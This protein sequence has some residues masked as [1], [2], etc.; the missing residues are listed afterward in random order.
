MAAIDADAAEATE[1]SEGGED[2]EMEERVAG[3]DGG[4][5]GGSRVVGGTIEEEETAE[6]REG[7]SEQRYEMTGALQSETGEES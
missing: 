6:N 5:G 7:S 2:V 3:Y 1:E 4:G